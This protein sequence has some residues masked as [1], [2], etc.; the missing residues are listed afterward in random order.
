MEHHSTE[1]DET[2]FLSKVVIA[3]FA[4]ALAFIGLTAV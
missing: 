2:S 1:L 4:A 3:I